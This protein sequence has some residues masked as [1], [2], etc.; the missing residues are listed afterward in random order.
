MYWKRRFCLGGLLSVSGWSSLSMEIRLSIKSQYAF[1]IALWL[2][3]FSWR[4]KARNLGPWPFLRDLL[5]ALS[6]RLPSRLS[7][8]VTHGRRMLSLMVL[9]GMCSLMAS[10]NLSLNRV[11]MESMDEAVLTFS[12]IS[13][14]ISVQRS[15]DPVPARSLVGRHNSW[16][17]LC[18]FSAQRYLGETGLW[19]E[20]GGNISIMMTAV[21]LLVTSRSRVLPIS[22][23]APFTT[24]SRP[25]SWNISR[26]L[27]CSIAPGWP[28]YMAWRVPVHVG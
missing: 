11:Q 8:V 14:C 20:N 17:L 10:H 24:F 2:S 23:V 5:L 27:S 21:G 13:C 9:V 3:C 22:C 18:S 28:W 7:L 16:I 19:S 4:A 6:R 12:R 25:L 26:H 1:L 15:P